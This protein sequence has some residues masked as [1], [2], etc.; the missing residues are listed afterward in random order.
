[1]KGLL[2]S[3][4]LVSSA[5]ADKVP[6]PT[7]LAQRTSGLVFKIPDN[8]L[9]LSPTAP[10]ANF[11]QAPPQ[12]EAM[13]KN[14]N[15]ALFAFDPKKF[16]TGFAENFNVVSVKSPMPKVD[17]ATA[18]RLSEETRDY[19]VRTMPGST[20]QVNEVGIVELEGV[21]CARWIADGSFSGVH[22]R[23]LVYAVPSGGEHAILTYSSTPT[24]FAKYLPLFDASAKA[25]RGV[26]P[27]TGGLLSRNLGSAALKGA[28]IGGLAAALTVAVLILVAVGRRKKQG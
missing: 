21:P 22:V 5:S 25:T 24:D 18:K 19:I 3:L 10:E 23:Q 17:A 15:Y 27:P 2:L 7:T 11:K 9:D 28:I 26:K 1:M 6:G 14:G 8:W 13:I 12:V 4:A 20:Y 16:G